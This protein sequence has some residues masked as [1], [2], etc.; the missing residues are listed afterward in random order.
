MHSEAVLRAA[1]GHGLVRV[2]RTSLLGSKA[3]GVAIHLMPRCQALRLAPAVI[4]AR[5]AL[6]KCAYT[7]LSSRRH[8]SY[9][10]AT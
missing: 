7:D 3:K 1:R 8:W 9:C 2:V 6:V 5:S 4:N 10:I